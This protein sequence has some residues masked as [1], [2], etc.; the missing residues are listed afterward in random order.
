[1]KLEN[2]KLE[3]S[4]GAT[5]TLYLHDIME[6][7]EKARPIVLVTPGGAYRFC[8][9]REAEPVA[10]AFYNAGYHAAVLRYSCMED[11]RNMQPMA[12]ALESIR[13]LREH[14]EKWHILADKIAV[15]GFSAGGH[16]AAST[17]TM[18][19]EPAL[20][21]RLNYEGDIL[22]PNALILGYPVI[23]SGEFAHRESFYNIS[24]SPEDDE[25]SG[26]YSLEKRVTGET[27]PTF[28][29]HTEDDPAVTVENALLFVS[30]LRKH[31]VPFECHIFNKGEHGLSLCNEEVN[32]P[33]PHCAHWFGLCIEWLDSIGLGLNI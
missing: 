5:L 12:E 26:F 11:A 28:I 21:K 18:W 8:S 19:N 25:T 3:I 22:K 10:I 33:N 30:A 27:P 7:R 15:C 24:G 6:L 23:T 32:T 29:W 13:I 20:M 4:S 14:A 1:M 17:G 31:Q 2:I 16:L 9:E